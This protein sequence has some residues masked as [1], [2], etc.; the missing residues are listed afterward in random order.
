MICINN[1]DTRTDREKLKVAFS[2]LRRRLYKARLGASKN[3]VIRMKQD[4]EF[5]F[6]WIAPKF[7]SYDD[8]IVHGPSRWDGETDELTGT[9]VINF[10]A[11]CDHDAE[12]LGEVL[13]DMLTGYGFIVSWNGNSD[14]AI[15][16]SK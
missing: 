9:L 2:H 8:T 1:T 12:R 11:H 16:V 10:Q 15:E 3:E 4:N 7:M 5:G 13:A 6:A 14:Q